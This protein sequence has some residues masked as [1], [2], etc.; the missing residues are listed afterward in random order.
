MKVY[1]D[2]RARGLHIT[3][4]LTYDH[5]HLNPYSKIKVY[6]AVQALSA[7]VAKVMVPQCVHSSQLTVV[8][9]DY[10]NLSMGCKHAACRDSYLHPHKTV[11]DNQPVVESLGISLGFSK[12]LYH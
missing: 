6:L 3:P 4:K 7:T 5:L 11:L 1:N 12:I 10:G 9:A 8:L 2:D